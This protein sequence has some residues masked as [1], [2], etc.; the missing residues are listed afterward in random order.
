M[1]QIFTLKKSFLKLEII[2]IQVKIRNLHVIIKTNVE[3]WWI[4]KNQFNDSETREFYYIDNM[5]CVV[6]RI[7][8]TCYISITSIFWSIYFMIWNRLVFTIGGLTGK[9]PIAI[10]T[11]AQ[12]S[13]NNNGKIIKK[14]DVHYNSHSS[15]WFWNISL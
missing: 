15:L 10:K 7:H 1:K 4:F 9:S 6:L 2:W 5:N 14:K 3:H 8:F 12:F 11:W 13:V